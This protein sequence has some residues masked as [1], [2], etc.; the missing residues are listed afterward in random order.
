MEMLFMPPT[1]YL[2]QKCF[3]V[4]FVEF[5]TEQTPHLG[6]SSLDQF[7]ARRDKDAN[8]HILLLLLVIPHAGLS[9]W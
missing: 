5:T 3:W 8:L 6:L 9:S 7:G 4:M 1:Q 2:S